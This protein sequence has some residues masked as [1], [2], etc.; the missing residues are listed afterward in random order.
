MYLTAQKQQSLGDADDS[1]ATTPYNS[2]G[3]QTQI[4]QICCTPDVEPVGAGQI[5]V[6]LEKNHD[7]VK[8][9]TKRLSELPQFPSISPPFPYNFLLLASELYRRKSGHCD[10]RKTFQVSEYNTSW[11]TRCQH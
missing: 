8:I 6:H 7:D 3:N 1:T 10:Q 4:A 11:A 5:T 2:T 9:H